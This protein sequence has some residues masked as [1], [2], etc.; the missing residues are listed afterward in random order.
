MRKK[1]SAIQSLVAKAKMESGEISFPD[2]IKTV[3]DCITKVGNSLLFW[4]NDSSGNTKAVVMD[5]D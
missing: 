1:M 4:Y 5:I 2:Q 3:E